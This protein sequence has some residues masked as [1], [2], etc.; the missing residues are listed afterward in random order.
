MRKI[1]LTI[2][3]VSRFEELAM[4]CLKDGLRMR[5]RRL[6]TGNTEY[7]CPHCGRVEIWNCGGTVPHTDTKP[8]THKETSHV[9][10]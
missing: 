10:R 5:E 7:T 3:L 4:Y 6:P 8:T 2:W 9:S 1:M